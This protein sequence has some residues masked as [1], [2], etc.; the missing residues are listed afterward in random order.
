MRDWTLCCFHNLIS[1]PTFRRALTA[2]LDS[3]A[4]IK[5]ALQWRNQFWPSLEEGAGKRCSGCGTCRNATL[6]VWR[7][8]PENDA[9]STEEVAENDVRSVEEG[10]GKRCSEYGGSCRKTMF[11]VRRKV[12][13]SYDWNMEEGAGKLCL[14]YGRRCRKAILGV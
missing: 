8:V 5:S 1:T 11:G 6:G 4:E 13:E 7:K 14:E 3:Y 10:A 9:R 2:S 12:P